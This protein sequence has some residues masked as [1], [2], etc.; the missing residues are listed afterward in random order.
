MAV[1]FRQ[2]FD[3]HKGYVMAGKYGV[4]SD[5]FFDLGKDELEG[6]A[7]DLGAR[8]IKDVNVDV[9]ITGP[10]KAMPQLPRP[11]RQERPAGAGSFFDCDDD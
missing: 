5:G 8:G 2:G 1:M 9:T 10:Q 7:V 11:A 6:T 3:T 4:P